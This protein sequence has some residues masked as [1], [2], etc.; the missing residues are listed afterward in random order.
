[1]RDSFHIMFSQNCN[2]DNNSNLANKLFMSLCKSLECSLT[3]QTREVSATSMNDMELD[4][5][6]KKNLKTRDVLKQ[7]M[8]SVV[9]QIIIWGGPP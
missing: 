3:E 1:M 6:T 2:P 7:K 9:Q 4:E 5:S 8:K